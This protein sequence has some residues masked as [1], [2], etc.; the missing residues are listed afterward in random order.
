[1]HCATNN[2][3]NNKKGI[4]LSNYGMQQKQQKKLI[5]QALHFVV[6]TLYSPKSIL[7]LV[8]QSCFLER[9][10]LERQS[11]IMSNTVANGGQTELIIGD[12]YTVEKEIG[13]GTFGRVYL[14]RNRKTLQKVAIKELSLQM[15]HN[16]GELSFVED[17]CRLLKQM[18]TDFHDNIIQLFDIVLEEHNGQPTLY[19]VFE[20]CE[21]GSLESTYEELVDGLS[22]EQAHSYFVQI[23]D[24]LDHLHKK[25]HIAHRDLQLQNI[26][27]TN[28]K[29]I[30]ICDFGLSTRFTPGKL[31][32]NQ[33]MGSAMYLSPEVHKREW[34]VGPELDVW[35]AGVCL[36]KMLTGYMPFRGADRIM[37]GSFTVPLEEEECLS[38]DCR[39][40]LANIFHPDPTKRFTIAQIKNH[41]WYRAAGA[42]Q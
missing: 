14:A 23:V 39:D 15:A 9:V 30:K 5:D 27:V 19:M 26:C 31:T 33:Y 32:S 2:N 34:Y 12:L 24:A 37:T 42:S 17:E 1:L 18:A 40:L 21:N 7:H 36:Y 20:Y 28:D 38:E 3:R 8:D 25:H 4:I 11:P 41:R 22:E 13:R 10:L 35:S 16:A 6:H 29:K